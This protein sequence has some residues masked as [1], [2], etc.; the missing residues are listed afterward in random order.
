M[1]Q[2]IPKGIVPGGQV[3]S[4]KKDIVGKPESGRS[5]RDELKGQDANAI[6]REST[7]PLGSR[8][9]PLGENRGSWREQEQKK[10][11]PGVLLTEK[12]K[13]E[14]KEAEPEDTSLGRRLENVLVGMLATAQAFDEAGELVRAITRKRESG[15]PVT[16]ADQIRPELAKLYKKLAGSR[17]A[18]QHA[19]M[20]TEDLVRNELLSGVRPFQEI[21]DD[22]REAFKISDPQEREKRIKELRKERA[23][24]EMIAEGIGLF[25]DVRNDTKTEQD[26]R[27]FENAGG[28]LQDHSE[29]APENDK[30]SRSFLNNRITE[31]RGLHGYDPKMDGMIEEYREVAKENWAWAMRAARGEATIDA[32]TRKRVEAR[33]WGTIPQTS[34][35]EEARGWLE[36]VR[37]V[38]ERQA[39]EQQMEH[40]RLL[41]EKMGQGA[42]GGGG[43]EVEV[44]EVNASGDRWSARF[45]EKLGLPV[46]FVIPPQ[47]P[48]APEI[49]VETASALENAY[50]TNG[51]PVFIN[52]NT[53]EGQYFIMSCSSQEKARLF[54]WGVLPWIRLI[55]LGRHDGKFSTLYDPKTGSGL[56]GELGLSL[57]GLATAFENDEEAKRCLAIIL[58]MNEQ[59]YPGGGGRRVLDGRR[60]MNTDD[61][62]FAESKAPEYMRLL[63]SD[64]LREEY[65][66]TA[67]R[68]E[69]R[70]LAA[71]VAKYVGCDNGTAEIMMEVATLINGGPKMVEYRNILKNHGELL[72][73]YAGERAALPLLAKLFMGKNAGGD[74]VYL[75][76]YFNNQG[77][78][79]MFQQMKGM[80]EDRW[81]KAIGGMVT[82][83]SVIDSIQK[84]LRW[85]GDA[86]EMASKYVVK[87]E[88]VK[89]LASLRKLEFP[90]IE[91]GTEAE[92]IG[93]AN[94]MP[95]KIGE[96]VKE[97]SP[98]AEQVANEV[99]WGLLNSLTFGGAGLLRSIRRKRGS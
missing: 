73:A 68:N 94:D 10:R 9:T 59:E 60:T 19:D 30:L 6:V 62:H 39:R 7:G 8:E 51:V 35:V 22:I 67:V 14:P 33:G 89:L 42:G 11:G 84:M 23:P 95:D 54:Y 16:H 52:P 4:E 86:K 72:S 65:G 47:G 46:N 15:E 61:V 21:Q 36:K 63:R 90:L 58:Q 40:E 56:I 2:E 44:R 82:I 41:A 37:G 85:D 74:S 92:I 76:D 53:V 27:F 93:R 64:P 31:V 98:P 88:I 50:D 34:L 66:H 43:A 87:C 75:A 26:W 78:D 28:N 17:G 25:D 13:E 38:N 49:R 29:I 57:R 91:R 70:D 5:L 99:G 24:L 96:V 83:K 81:H 32:D 12:L 79:G 97:S 69:I 71:E 45:M 80:Y 1:S 55:T 77:V 18:R 48:R 3:K 20:E